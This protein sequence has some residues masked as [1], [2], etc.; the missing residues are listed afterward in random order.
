MNT[1]FI[2][3]L[4]KTEVSDD[5]VEVDEHTRRLYETYL[6]HCDMMFQNAG[7]DTD[8]VVQVNPVFMIELFSID[9][10]TG[11]FGPC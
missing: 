5:S 1:D 4:K 10:A 6:Q 9:C 2:N 11:Y 7:Q 3:N 8:D